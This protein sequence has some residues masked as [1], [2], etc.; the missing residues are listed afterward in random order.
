M[1]DL[2][3]DKRLS[4]CHLP[5]LISIFLAFAEKLPDEMDGKEAR[6]IRDYRNK[7]AHDPVFARNPEEVKEFLRLTQHYVDKGLLG[8]YTMHVGADVESRLASTEAHERGHSAIRWDPEAGP[9][10]QPKSPACAEFLL[11][12]LLRQSDVDAIIGD[13]TEMYDQRL[14]SYGECR[15]RLW[16]YSQVALSIWP[17]L[18]R[19]ISTKWLRRLIP[20]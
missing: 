1:S 7:L 12:L 19:A 17:L 16:F 20:W 8:Q 5:Y 14:A 13:L 10:A 15:A 9:N 11:R 6:L 18:T 4:A 3:D 2:K